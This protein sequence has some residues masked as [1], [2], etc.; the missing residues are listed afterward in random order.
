[1]KLAP[2]AHGLRQREIEFRIIHTGQ[3]YDQKMSQTFFD[4]LDIPQPDVNLEVGAGDA[5]WQITEI[6]RRIAD[7]LQAF[8]PDWLVVVGDVNSTL[9]AALVAAK[10]SIPLV[11]VEAGLRSGDREMPEEINRILVDSCSDCLLASESDG[12]SNLLAEG[13]PKEKIHLVGNVMIDTLLSHLE[14]AKATRP[15]D[16]LGLM[17]QE[18]GLL[19]LH[20]PSNVDHKEHLVSIM[21]AI[22]EVS[23]QLPLVFPVHPRTAKQIERHGIDLSKMNIRVIEPVGYYEMVAFMEASRLVMTDSGGVQEET[24]ALRVPCLTLRENTERPSTITVGSNQ[25]V[26]WQA[27]RITS[28]FYDLLRQDQRIGQ[29]PEYWDG[30]TA[31]RIVDVLANNVVSPGAHEVGEQ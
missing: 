30:N 21:E 27:E 28:A 7:E 29:I 12:V 17:P 5:V 3:H 1:M 24:T 23:R 13:V 26:G 2:L 6:M 19:T 31:S 11:H 18:Y 9:A 16:T 20:R 4:E 15:Y 25:L 8:P 10:L 14:A 22:A